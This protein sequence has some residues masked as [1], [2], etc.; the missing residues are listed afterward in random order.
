MVSND[1][2]DIPPFFTYKTTTAKTDKSEI[3]GNSS[4]WNITLADLEVEK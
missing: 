4:G 2:Y 1:N 3:E